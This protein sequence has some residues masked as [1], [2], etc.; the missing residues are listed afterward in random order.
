[1]H[2]R[3][4]EPQAEIEPQI[5]DA[6]KEVFAARR[7]LTLAAQRERVE[8]RAACARS[9]GDVR[10]ELDRKLL[11][12]AGLED[13]ELE[14]ARSEYLDV[15]RRTAAERKAAFAERLPQ[16]AA[17][18]ARPV[19]EDS[20]AQFYFA[21][22]IPEAYAVQIEESD[23]SRSR[24][25]PRCGTRACASTWRGRASSLTASGSDSCS[26]GRTLSALRRPQRGGGARAQRPLLQ[27]RRRRPRLLRPG[28]Q[29]LPGRDRRAASHPARTQLRL[30]RSV[31]RGLR[32]HSLR[33]WRLRTRP[34]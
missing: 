24:L 29:R 18:A 16:D 13:G 23:A 14:R 1:M 31:D 10:R 21:N 28:G 32:H 20:V 17:R 3:Q 5:F 12:A 22:W 11:A 8:T 26:V 19:V 25:R 33:G 30:R 9:P 27:R 2:Q 6:A 4:I 7:S 34:G 15:A